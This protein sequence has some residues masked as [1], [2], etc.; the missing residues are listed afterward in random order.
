MSKQN[1]SRSSIDS[2]LSKKEQLAQQYLDLAG[3]MFVAIDNEG[4]VTLINRKGCEILGCDENDIVGKN[5][6]DN[7]IPESMRSNVKSVFNQLINDEIEPVEYFENPVIA[8]EGEERM[9]A[10]HNTLIHDDDGRIVSTLSSGED[11]TERKK[12]QEELERLNRELEKRVLRRTA[13]LEAANKEL[14]AFAYSVSHDLRSPV[15]IMVGFSDLLLRD[16]SEQLDEKARDYLER[17]SSS[18]KRMGTLIDDLLKLSRITKSEIAA[19]RIDL[20]AMAKR[21]ADQLRDSEPDRNVKFIIEEDC[22]AMGDTMLISAA[23][24]NILHNAFKFTRGVKKARIEFGHSIDGKTG[25][26]FVRDNGVGFDPEY[27]HKLFKAFQRLHSQEE[28]EGSGIGL[29]T[30]ERIIRRHGGSVWAQGEVNRGAT[31]Y[32]ALPPAGREKTGGA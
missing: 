9:I 3:V 28:Y 6:F 11:I 5:W 23:M 21:I 2:A 17:I 15:R 31:V 25:A 16:I 10:W 7:F 14:E 19:K 22:T 13:Q 1:Q 20:S 12:A 29:A 8:A 26:W 24:E 32:F 4:T 30:V 27:K 18:A